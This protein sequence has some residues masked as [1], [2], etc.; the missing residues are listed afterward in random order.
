MNTGQH[1]RWHALA[2][3]VIAGE[4][5]GEQDALAV[6]RAPDT[7]VLTIVD[8]A[9]RVR[10]TYYGHDVKLNAIMNVKSGLCP[11]DCGYCAQSIVST[12]NIAKYAMLD[13]E[14]IVH[15]AQ[16][17]HARAVGTYCIVASGRG[18]TDNELAHVIDAVREIK[19]TLP[20]KICACLGVLRPEQAQRLKDA[21]VDRYNHNLNTESSH[22]SRI[23][24]THTYA[25]RVQ[26]VQRAAEAGMS[27]CSG[28]IVGMGETDEQRVRLAFALRDLDADS[29]PINFL[30]PIDGTPLQHM[31]T[32][33]PWKCLLVLAMVRF[34]CPTKEI[35]ASGGREVQLRSLQ[36]LA[37]YVANSLFLGDYLTTSGQSDAADMAMIDD[38]GFVIERDAFASGP[39]RV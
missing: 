39:V 35:R 27:P 13:R 16:R 21:G 24:T 28:M 38:I 37:L 3:R 1:G 26:T 34:V 5:I 11:E 14:T 32:L 31:R 8:A 29:I 22:F 6:L 36:P 17:A 9:Y 15:G 4:P 33:T 7:D 25:D 12:A 19:Q 2:D 10:R 20:L 30:H 18:P 23:T